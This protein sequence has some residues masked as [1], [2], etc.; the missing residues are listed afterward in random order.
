MTTRPPPPISGTMNGA[1]RHRA[2]KYVFYTNYY[3]QLG[4]AD[5][6][7]WWQPWMKNTT[8]HQNQTSRQRTRARDADASRASVCFLFLFPFFNCTNAYLQIYRLRAW[9][10]PCS[11]HGTCQDD[12]FNRGFL[13]KNYSR[14]KTA[15]NGS[16]ATMFHI[17]TLNST[18]FINRQKQRCQQ[19]HRLAF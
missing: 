4:Y 1:S 15:T 3:L 18:T 13:K 7:P 5:L 10:L 8:H 17:I 12:P 11:T 9:P 19:A 6:E 2:P 16:T 14:M